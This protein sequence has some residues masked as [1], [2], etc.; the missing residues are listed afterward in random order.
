MTAARI[1][2]AL[3]KFIIDNFFTNNSSALRLAFREKDRKKTK[4]KML[5]IQPGNGSILAQFVFL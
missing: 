3:V 4:Q 2:D 1:L 5:R